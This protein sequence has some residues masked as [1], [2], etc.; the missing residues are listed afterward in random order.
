M[1]SLELAEDEI[2]ESLSIAEQL[3]QKIKEL[4]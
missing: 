2:R 3:V 4:T 1:L